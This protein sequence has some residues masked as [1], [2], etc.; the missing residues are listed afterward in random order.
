MIEA[1]Y[2]TQSQQADL[3]LTEDDIVRM[4]E[5]SK[6]PRIGEK[7][8]NRWACDGQLFR[9]N[10]SPYRRKWHALLFFLVLKLNFDCSIAP[11]IYGWRNI[12]TAL[13]LSMFGGEAKQQPKKKVFVL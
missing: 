7:I 13:A 12:K 6:D 9:L 4:R 1:N 2:V 3:D 8:I 11:S 10:G 5:L